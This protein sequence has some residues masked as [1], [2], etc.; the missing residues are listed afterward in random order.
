MCY[1]Y[2][3]QLS[4]AW[5]QT[6]VG[7]ALQCTSAPV[8]STAQIIA[9]CEK[10]NWTT[11]LIFLTSAHAC[12]SL[13]EVLTCWI[14]LDDLATLCHLC[15]LEYLS[16]LAFRGLQKSEEHLRPLTALTSLR[17]EHAL[18]SEREAEILF[19]G[20]WDTSYSNSSVPY[21]LIIHMGSNP[22][23]LFHSSETPLC[24]NQ[25]MWMWC[26]L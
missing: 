18:G 5:V 21:T 6:E 22:S 15:R 4:R 14:L 17:L 7:A 2:L 1:G 23:V 9:L 13:L 25:I 20:Q 24:S 16:V 3:L 26:S 11:L 8:T 19:R 12:M 10:L